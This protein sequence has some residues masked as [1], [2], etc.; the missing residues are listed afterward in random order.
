MNQ[1]TV[2]RVHFCFSSQRQNV[3]FVFFSVEVVLRVM[4]ANQASPRSKMGRSLQW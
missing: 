1:V 3:F 4:N 2:G